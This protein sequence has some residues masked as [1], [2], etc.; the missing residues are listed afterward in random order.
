MRIILT[1][2]VRKLGTIGDIVNVKD[3][4]ARNYLLPRNFAVV[5]NE[6]NKAELEHQ[7]RVL[8]RKSAKVLAEF[9]KLAS[10]I[11][12]V[13][14]TIAK[15][16]GEDEKIFGTVTSAE[17]EAKLKEAGVEVDRRDIVLTEEVKKVGVYN[18]EVRLHSK[19]TAKLKFWVVADEAD[20]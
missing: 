2:D 17:L 10:N 11:E 15:K 16:T 20:A 1:Q 19:I 3:G 7:K 13:S 8:E 4:Y 5:A 6:S 18:A 12:K 9:K 14:V